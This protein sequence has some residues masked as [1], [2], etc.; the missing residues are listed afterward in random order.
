[1][2]VQID[3][4]MMDAPIPRWRKALGWGLYDIG[5]SAYFLVFSLYLFPVYLS[6]QK[7]AGNPKFELYWGITQGLAVLLAVTTGLVLGKLLD[8]K[9]LQRVAPNIITFASFS[10]FLLP[11]LIAFGATPFLLLGG[12][13]VVHSVYLVSLTVYDASLIR[14]ANP[15]ED[16]AAVSGWAWGW[17]YVGGLMCMGLMEV[18]LFFYPRFSAWDFGVGA[19]FYFV[20][21]LYAA[22]WLRRTLGE[23]SERKMSVGTNRGITSR[24]VSTPWGLLL[25][26]LLVVDGI[27][28]FM[29]YTGIYGTRALGLEERQMTSML[30]LLQLLAFPLTGIVATIGARNVPKAL[31]V[32]GVGWLATVTVLVSASGIAGMLMTIVIVSSIVGSTQALLRALFADKVTA[33]REIEGFGRYAVV[34]KGAAFIG[35][36]IAGSLI[37]FVGYRSVLFASGV[38][39]MLGTLLIWKL[40]RSKDSNREEFS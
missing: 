34:E 30:G 33:N 1:M 23:Q 3:N 38:V 36:V 35:P 9:G 25:A 32:C 12:F 5:N 28:V 26:M 20:A 6:Q 22:R 18:G 16:R 10:T 11:I 21:S 27:A 7:F 4:S 14:V 8:S 31:V 29:S 40:A 17:G 39:I 24:T 13:V 15:G 2:D 19:I 37:P